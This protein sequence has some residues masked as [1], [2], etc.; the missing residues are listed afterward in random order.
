MTTPPAERHGLPAL[1]A[2][3]CLREDHW[4]V[5]HLSVDLPVAEVI[6]LALEVGADLVVLS[7]ATAEAAR[8]ARRAARLIGSSAPR[9][10]VL[11]G[12]PGHAEQ[13]A[14]TGPARLARVGRRAVT[15]DGLAVRAGDLAGAVGMDSQLP[16]E[17]VQHHVVVPVSSSP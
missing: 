3:A 16:A 8:A 14:G 4:L 7:T 6:G 9:L 12:L 1:M 17:L 5:H 13:A 2:A 15:V 11:V 10:R